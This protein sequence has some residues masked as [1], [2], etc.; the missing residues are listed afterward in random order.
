MGGGRKEGGSLSNDP[1]SDPDPS[2]NKQFTILWLLTHLLSL[3]A[4]INVLY[5]LYTVLDL[6]VTYIVQCV[7][8]TKWKKKLFFDIL[9]VTKKKSWI[10]SRIRYPGYWSGIRIRTKMPRMRTTKNE[11]LS[12]SKSGEYK[13]SHKVHVGISRNRF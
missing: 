6:T 1:A 3:K 5:Q 9:N 2:I 4:D 8:S 10:L 11:A 13:S 12:R 7:V